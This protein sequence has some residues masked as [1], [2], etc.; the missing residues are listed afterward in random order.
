MASIFSIFGGSA[1]ALEVGDTVPD[2]IAKNQNGQ[3][4]RLTNYKGKYVFIYFYPKDETPGCTKEAVCLRNDYSKF[5]EL[6]AVVF[7]VSRQDERSHKKFAE[8]Y[9]LP[10]DLL[11]DSDG[12]IARMLGIGAIPILGLTKRQS[13]LIGPDGKVLKVYRDVDP[14]KHS[15]QVLEDLKSFKK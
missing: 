11:V 12:S 3:L 13:L 10:F 9:K 2:V 5:G 7:G 1:R 15:D 8:K 4:I 14:S 6:N